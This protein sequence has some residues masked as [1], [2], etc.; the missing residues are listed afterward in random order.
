MMPWLPP[1]SEEEIAAAISRMVAPWRDRWFIGA[2]SLSCKPLHKQGL[3]DMA[4]RPAVIISAAERDEKAAASEA[5]GQQADPANPRDNDLLARLG[6]AIALDLRQSLEEAAGE[7]DGGARDFT[8]WSLA[9][10]SD[11]WSIDL[12]LST[13]AVCRIR[14]RAAGRRSEPQLGKLQSAISAETVSIGCHLGSARITAG[15]LATLTP[16]E[17]IMFDRKR[18]D[19]VPL[20]VNGVPASIGAVRIS[21]SA[22]GPVLTLAHPFAFSR[23]RNLTHAR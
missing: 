6:R 1:A 4:P 18:S 23:N 3:S 5:I 11:N 20:V 21:A 19:T 10:S 15:E 22:D 8:W 9:L 12:G 17:V 7:I 13:G 14:Q 2:P 16:G